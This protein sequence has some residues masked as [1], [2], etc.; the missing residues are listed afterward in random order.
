M[1]QIKKLAV[2][3]PEHPVTRR[4]RNRTHRLCALE[5]TYGRFTTRAILGL[6]VHFPA[7]KSKE[8]LLNCKS[9]IYSCFVDVEAAAAAAASRIP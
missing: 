5:D 3:A 1:L 2:F 7:I 9:H 6:R 4:V 8:T